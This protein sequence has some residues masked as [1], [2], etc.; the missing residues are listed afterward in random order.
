MQGKKLYQHQMSLK[1][2]PHTFCNCQQTS[3]IIL[4]DV[5][6]FFLVELVEFN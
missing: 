3:S 4:A 2:Q 6:P 5:W 1:N